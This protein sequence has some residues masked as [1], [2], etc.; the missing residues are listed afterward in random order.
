MGTQSHET[1]DNNPHFG[2]KEIDYLTRVEAAMQ[3]PVQPT[4]VTMWLGKAQEEGLDPQRIYEAAV[5]ARPP[6][7][8]KAPPFSDVV[9]PPRNKVPM[10][11]V[12][13]S[14]K[15]LILTW[16]M[17]RSVLSTAPAMTYP[18]EPERL[19]LPSLQASEQSRWVLHRISSTRAWSTS[20]ATP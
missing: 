6:H 19:I 4:T 9:P 18:L 14:N 17:M 20:K 7:W 11:Y 10:Q 8:T 15:P 12:K 13:A 3:N 5:K 1:S 16:R 2:K